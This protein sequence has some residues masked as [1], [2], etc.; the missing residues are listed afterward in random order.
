MRSLPASLRQGLFAQ[1]H[2]IAHQPICFKLDGSGSIIFDEVRRN[3]CVIDEGIVPDGDLAR[4]VFAFASFR[5]DGNR[6][7]L[8]LRQRPLFKPIARYDGRA[9]IGQIDQIA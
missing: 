2:H 5:A 8:V 3:S 4:R 9:A 7:L 1:R 6:R